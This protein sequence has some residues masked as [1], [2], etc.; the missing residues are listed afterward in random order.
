MYAVSIFPMRKYLAERTLSMRVRCL[1]L[2]MRFHSVGF[3]SCAPTCRKAN[4][5]NSPMTG[6]LI[7]FRIMGNCALR[8]PDKIASVGYTTYLKQ[9]F[10]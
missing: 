10:A 3:F 5:A 8:N 7:L 6:S 9:T 2:V 4:M 1:L